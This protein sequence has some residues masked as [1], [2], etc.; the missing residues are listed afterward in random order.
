[1]DV[2]GTVSP[3]SGIYAYIRGTVSPRAESI[4]FHV[5]V[6]GTVSPESA[7]DA[8]IRGTVSPRAEPIQFYVE[9]VG[10]ISPESG[11]WRSCWQM[12]MP[13]NV[14]AVW[15]S[16]RQVLSLELHI[17]VYAAFSGPQ[18]YHSYVGMSPEADEF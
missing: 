16:D 6:F 1:M 17:V 9:V 15:R 5:E 4:H 8:Y 13:Q 3:E 14:H 7:I 11:I 12:C 2:L 10:T 18:S